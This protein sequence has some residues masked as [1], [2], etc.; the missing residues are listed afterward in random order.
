M[1]SQLGMFIYDQ[2]QFACLIPA[3]FLNKDNRV[4]IAI[5]L[6]SILISNI[7]A[8]SF[9]G[10]V[11]DLT[12][13][14]I[15]ILFCLAIAI[16]VEKSFIK[17]TLII[18]TSLLILLLTLSAIINLGYIDFSVE[19]A[20]FYILIGQSALLVAVNDRVISGVIGIVTRAFKMLYSLQNLQGVQK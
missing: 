2:W 11:L 20:I 6:I 12:S 4:A 8:Y 1:L 16:F 7:P 17:T 5:Y 9:N 13:I 18:T 3:Y 15:C 19:D 14:D 10:I